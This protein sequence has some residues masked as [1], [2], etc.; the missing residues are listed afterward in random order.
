MIGR[1]WREVDIEVYPK[2]YQLSATD[3]PL[4]RRM[5]YAS[6]SL[7]TASPRIRTTHPQINLFRVAG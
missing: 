5:M 2:A 1:F 4:S 6:W 3:R 7:Q